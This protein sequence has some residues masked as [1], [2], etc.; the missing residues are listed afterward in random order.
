MGCDDGGNDGPADPYVGA[1]NFCFVG[2]VLPITLPLSA[3]PRFSRNRA[4]ARES[5]P[6]GVLFH[7]LL[8]A[9]TVPE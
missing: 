6:Q 8:E 2:S 5:H 4:T 1:G 9:E 7:R 3:L